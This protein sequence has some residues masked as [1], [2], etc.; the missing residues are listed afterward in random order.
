MAFSPPTNQ[1]RDRKLQTYIYYTFI[2]IVLVTLAL[3]LT[4][5]I[6]YAA[7]RSVS[8]LNVAHETEAHRTV[9]KRTP[10]PQAV[11]ERQRR[12]N[13]PKRTLYPLTV[14]SHYVINSPN[15]CTNVSNLKFLIIVHTS[16]D[17]FQ[18][19]RIMRETWA[20]KNIFKTVNLR[21]VFFFGLTKVKA[22]QDLIENESIVYGDVV[23]GNF[24]D[25]YHNLTHKGVLGV[26]VDSGLLS[27][28]REMIVKVDD[29]V[30]LNV[31]YPPGKFLPEVQI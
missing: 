26:Q 18:R 19:R 31:F 24:L 27:A 9:V 8:H 15:V 12:R 30:F 21:I 25:T 2:L 16:T 10:H 14:E 23:Q 28:G 3:Y 4:L 22:T 6:T 17:H 5:F 20:N 1:P 11:H 7:D 13:V 29:D